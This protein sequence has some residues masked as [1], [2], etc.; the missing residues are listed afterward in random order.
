M[1]SIHKPIEPKQDSS[2]KLCLKWWDYLFLVNCFAG[3]N[4]KRGNVNDCVR[5]NE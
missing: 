1:Q 4:F 2:E 3:R 5:L